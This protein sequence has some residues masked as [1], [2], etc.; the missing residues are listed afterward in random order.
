MEIILSTFV[1]PFSF[2][3]RTENDDIGD[4]NFE[5]HS[6]ENVRISNKVSDF[7]HGQYVAVMWKERWVRGVVTMENQFLIWLVDYGIHLRPNDKTVII[8]LPAEYKKYP[9]KV[10]EASIHGVSPL[11]KELTHDGQ[12]K[13]KLSTTWNNGAIDK[14]KELIANASKKYFV[15]IAILSTKYNDIVL[16]DLYLVTKDKGT[17]NI[18][19]ELQVW[20]VFLEKNAEDY[21]KKLPIHYTSRRKHRASLLKPEFSKTIPTV[22]EDLSMAQ[23]KNIC[24]SVPPFEQANEYDGTSEDG[25]TV[26][27]IVGRKKKYDPKCAGFYR[28]EA[29]LPHVPGYRPA[30]RCSR[31]HR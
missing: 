16:G 29:C 19:D 13:N 26:V 30:H 11:D 6:S 25:S 31:V 1:S 3:C 17:V 7:V 24:A 4:I 21:I 2:F 22:Y 14:A 10:F 18:A 20:P 27:T 15:P 5:S 23:Y 28:R 9:T 12:M 8:D